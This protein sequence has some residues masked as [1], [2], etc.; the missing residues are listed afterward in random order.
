MRHWKPSLRYPTEAWWWSD[1]APT[2][3]QAASLPE[4]EL[5]EG[6]QLDVVAGVGR[7]ED[8]P[9]PHIESFVAWLG[10]DDVPR[11]E[12]ALPDR[13]ALLHLVIC[14]PADPQVPGPPIGRVD[15]A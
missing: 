10:E 8:H 14:R 13:D 3:D 1:A 6:D 4:T 12:L 7:F 11:L 2:P 9:V 5:L 15:E